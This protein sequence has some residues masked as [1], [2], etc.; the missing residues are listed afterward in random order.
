M[1]HEM[2]PREILFIVEKTVRRI[3]SREMK[4]SGE[5]C[6]LYCCETVWGIMSHEMKHSENPDHCSETR[7][8]S[9]DLQHIKDT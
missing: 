6:L 9:N 1:S 8:R 5:S 4:H 3:M 2:T 7:L